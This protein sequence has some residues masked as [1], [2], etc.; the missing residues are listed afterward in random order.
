[1]A[2]KKFTVAD[3]RGISLYLRARADSTKGRKRELLISYADTVRWAAGRI[4][5]QGKHG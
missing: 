1:M 5:I 2:K 4:E 3:L